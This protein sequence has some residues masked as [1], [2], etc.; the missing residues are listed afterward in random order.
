[1]N[2]EMKILSYQTTISRADERV[3]FKETSCPQDGKLSLEADEPQVGQL[4]EDVEK[5]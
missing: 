5:K 4:H 3:E 2:P 1:M